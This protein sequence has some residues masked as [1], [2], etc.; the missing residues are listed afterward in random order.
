VFT[1]II[2][3]IKCYQ[4]SIYYPDPEDNRVVTHYGYYFSHETNEYFFSSEVMMKNIE[5][6]YRQV[7]E[8]GTSWA[9]YTQKTFSIK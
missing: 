9:G 4:T 3:L 8:P 6:F 1:K 7:V 5:D 2:F